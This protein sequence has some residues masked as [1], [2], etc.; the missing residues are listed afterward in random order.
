MG[1][2]VF[3]GLGFLSVGVGML[4]IVVPG[5]PTTIFLIL[6]LYCFRKSSP[7]FER[8]L[9]EHPRFGHVL[10]D[11]EKNKCIRPAVKRK[12]IATLWVCM[13]ITAGIF[14]FTGV[15]PY[16]YGILAAVGAAIT[17]Y[18]ASRRGEPTQVFEASK[19]VS[20]AA[21]TPTPVASRR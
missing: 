10:R 6:A 5:L 17:W 3:L 12:A 11:W 4:G 8:W 14:A 19:M 7:R 18:I 1:R 13:A 15:S 21:S 9:L 2:K 16:A 20:D